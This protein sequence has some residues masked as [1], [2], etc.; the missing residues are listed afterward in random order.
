[1]ENPN[2]PFDRRL[3]CNFEFHL[4]QGLELA[5]LVL[6]GRGKRKMRGTSVDKR[7]KFHGFVTICGV[8]DLYLT[9]YPTHALYS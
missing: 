6:P 3:V 5:Q 1:M 8:F 2:L 9:D 7:T 4:A